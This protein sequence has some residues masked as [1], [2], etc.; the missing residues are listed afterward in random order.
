MLDG[1]SVGE[2]ARRFKVSRESLHVWLPRYAADQGLGGDRSSRRLID[3]IDLH[4]ARCCWATESDS[5]TPLPA[6]PYTCNALVSIRHRPL[7]FAIAR[8]AGTI[9]A[10]SRVKAGE[11]RNV[12]RLRR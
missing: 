10:R 9:S 5:T 4:L 2:V 6:S 7:A 8:L 12:R 11:P 3:E 1:A